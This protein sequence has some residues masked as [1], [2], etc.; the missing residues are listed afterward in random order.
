MEMP[1][2]MTGPYLATRLVSFSSTLCFPIFLN[3]FFIWK[4]IPCLQWNEALR[5]F[6][7]GVPQKRHW[8]QL[9]KYENCFTSA[10][11][12]NWL[13]SQHKENPQF[14]PAVSNEQIQQLLC[15][16]LK[17]GVFEDFRDIGTK[18]DDRIETNGLYR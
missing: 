11:A 3:E 7:N 1:K 12:T 15:K 9:R 8:R 2:P 4:K 16:F 10:E 13:H 17:A 18:T 5:I 6:N 14:G